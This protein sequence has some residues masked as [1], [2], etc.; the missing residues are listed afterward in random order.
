MNEYVIENDYIRL[1]FLDYGAVITSLFFKKQGLDTVLSYDNYED[2]YNNDIQLGVS[3]VGD[4]AGRI[5]NAKYTINDVTTYL[6]KNLKEHSIHG[7][8]NNLSNS[9]FKVECSKCFATLSCEH[10][11]LDIKIVF[12]LSKDK[13]KQE[14]FAKTTKPIVFNPTNHTYFNLDSSD[15]MNYTLNLDSDYMYYLDKDSLA[16]KKIKLKNTRF[17]ILNGKE[18]LRNICSSQFKYTK[19]IDHPFHLKS[20][21]IKLQSDKYSLNIKTNQ[22]Y[23]VIYTGN[24]LKDVKKKINNRI[25]KD[26][27]GICIE[28]QA[29]PNGINMK[30]ES[31]SILKPNE[32]FYYFN[33]YHLSKLKKTQD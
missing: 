23:A 15:C 13:F 14:I 2:Y 12:S 4:Y 20:K 1:K 17:N 10:N 3:C 29:I 11:C 32:N 7:G 21:N 6:D 30:G 24:Y 25:S 31:G 33:E 19:Y 27:M 9:S 5:K 22:E 28:T 26:Y 18:Q 8:F 16:E